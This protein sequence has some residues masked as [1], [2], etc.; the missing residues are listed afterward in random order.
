MALI[1]C[2]E[3]GTKISSSAKACPLC[4][5][6][7]LRNKQFGCGT[8]IVIIIFASFI[9]S[10]F[11]EKTTPTKA[12]QSPQDPRKV[13]IEKAFSPWDG[14]H[15]QLESYIKKN[16][17]DPDSYQHIETRY[18]DNGNTITVTTKYRAKNS[19]GGYV[20]ESSVATAN[21]DGT[22]ITVNQLK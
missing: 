20:I 9:Y 21:I 22:L 14:S 19:F 8:I 15:R 6:E 16:L 17:K 10:Q 2:K 11:S 1:Q 12:S 7:L 4:G 5:K 3:C 18:A 13:T